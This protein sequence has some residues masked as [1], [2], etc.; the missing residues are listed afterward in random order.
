MQNIARFPP[1][2]KA[3]AVGKIN[4]QFMHKSTHVIIRRRRPVLRYDV[5]LLS[6]SYMRMPL[7]IPAVLLIALCALVLSPDAEAAELRYLDAAG[8]I[9][10]SSDARSDQ[11]EPASH[12]LSPEK[13]QVSF[14]SP[15]GHQRTFLPL[16]AAQ[17]PE[18]LHGV[19]AYLR[20]YRKD[21]LS[22]HF[23]SFTRHSGLAPPTHRPSRG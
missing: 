10:A 20:E 17:T 22:R 8:S 6:L 11:E 1:F 9:F 16:P 13:L 18:P 14:I 19:S 15:Q 2:S 21:R 23:F 7:I 4:L 5:L 3:K 12:H